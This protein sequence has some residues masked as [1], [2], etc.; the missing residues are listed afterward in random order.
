MDDLYSASIVKLD[1]ELLIENPKLYDNNLVDVK[2]YT[3]VKNIIVRKIN[4][5]VVQEIITGKKIPIIKEKI[6]NDGHLVINHYSKKS[7]GVLEQRLCLLKNSAT[8]AL[9]YLQYIKTNNK[10]NL[11]KLIDF[12]FF[13]SNLMMEVYEFYKQKYKKTQKSKVKKLVKK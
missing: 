11:E 12:I 8:D 2:Y 9:E 5:H 7:V 10:D 4:S 6:L 3:E 1:A 13:E